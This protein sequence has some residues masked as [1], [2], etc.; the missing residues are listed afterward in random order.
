MTNC[1]EDPC[2]YLRRDGKTWSMNKDTFTKFMKHVFCYF[3]IEESSEKL[4]IG[5]VQYANISEDDLN[6]AS[7]IFGMDYP[8]YNRAVL[9]PVYP[10]SYN[11]SSKD[12]FKIQ[13]FEKENETIL[14]YLLYLKH[15]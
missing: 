6:I 11:L 12:Y 1:G 10:K 13:I 9:V 8:N 14:S 5:N 7:F 3:Y 2:L 4:N 15:L